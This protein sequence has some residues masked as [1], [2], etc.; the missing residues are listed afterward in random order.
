MARAAIETESPL[1]DTGISIQLAPDQEHLEIS[2]PITDTVHGIARKLAIQVAKMDPVQQQ[3]YLQGV[4]AK[5]PQLHGII[6]QLLA[7]KQSPAAAPDQ[8]ANQPPLPAQLPPRRSVAP[9]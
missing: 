5:H 3:N 7:E 8:Q 9:I 2:G 4:Q 6:T 1:S